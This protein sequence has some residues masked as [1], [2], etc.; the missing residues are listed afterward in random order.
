MSE[1]RFTYRFVDGSEQEFAGTGDN[2]TLACAD[3]IGKLRKVLSSRGERYEASRMHVPADGNCIGP[4]DQTITREP[5][6]EGS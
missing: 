6:P 4:L 2:V 3:A 1:R 5:R